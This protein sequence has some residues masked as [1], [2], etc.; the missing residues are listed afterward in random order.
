M[1]EVKQLVKENRLAEMFGAGTA[2]IVCPVSSITYLGERI[3]IPTAEQENP[4]YMKVLNT[5][6]DIYYG[7]I[8]HPWGVLVE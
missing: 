3:D 8:H 2:C 5:L 1:R 6:S 7:K 4:V